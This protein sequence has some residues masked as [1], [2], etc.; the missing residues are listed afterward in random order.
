V[1]N[2]IIEQLVIIDFVLLVDFADAPVVEFETRLRLNHFFDLRWQTVMFLDF[3]QI[4]TGAV[5]RGQDDGLR[6]RIF[7][8]EVV[9]L[10]HL[11]R[12]EIAPIVVR[13]HLVLIVEDLVRHVVLLCRC[14]QVNRVFRVAHPRMGQD[15]MHRDSLL[16]VLL[17]ETLQ[18]VTS[19]F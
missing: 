1:V 8:R 14:K 18:Q 7:Q 16:G 17:K 13:A 11:V 10:K 3:F 6:L 9:C 5:E 4:R 15:S 19:I 2:A 12:K